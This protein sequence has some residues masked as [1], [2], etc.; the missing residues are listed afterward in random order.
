MSARSNLNDRNAK[1]VPAHLFQL[2]SLPQDERAKHA[3][4]LLSED[5]YVCK[6]FKVIAPFLVVYWWDLTFD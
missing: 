1:D 5:R 4:Y 6:S 2:I 3:E